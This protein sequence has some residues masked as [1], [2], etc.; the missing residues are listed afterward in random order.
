MKIL[1]K[2]INKNVKRCRKAKRDEDQD[3]MFE[4]VDSKVI[5]DS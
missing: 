2:R 3:K 1:T 4:L 5:Y